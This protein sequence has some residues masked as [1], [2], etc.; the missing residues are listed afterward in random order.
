MQNLRGMGDIVALIT[1]KTGI[2]WVVDKVSNAIGID[3][4]CPVRQEKINVKL[5]FNGTR[6]D[7]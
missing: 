4:N 1:E 3:C 5:P 6:K 2:K 7:S